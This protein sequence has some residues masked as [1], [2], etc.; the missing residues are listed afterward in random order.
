MTSETADMIFVEENGVYQ[1]DCTAAIWATDKMHSDYQNAKLHIK[2]ADFLIETL[3]EIIIVEYKNANIPNAKNPQSFDPISDKKR[4]DVY[5]KFYDSL[6]YLR[7]LGK[8]KPINYVYILEYPK[9]DRVTRKRIRG[10]LKCEL[11]FELQ[12]LIGNGRKLIEKVDVLSIEEW[13][14]NEIYGRYPIQEIENK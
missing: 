3:N 6:H 14:Q 9:G 4:K 13:N 11:P 10:K 2:D 7:L 1:I 5:Q 12:K 8:D